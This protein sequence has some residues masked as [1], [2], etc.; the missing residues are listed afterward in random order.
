MCSIT[1]WTDGAC[2]GN[3]GPGGYAAILTY[4]EF[5]KTIAGF[6]PNTTNNRMELRAVLE[7]IKLLK[8]PCQISVYTDSRYVSSN[9]ENLESWAQKGWK[10]YRGK[11]L[12]NVDLWQQIRDTVLAGGHVIAFNHVAGH[13]GVELNEKCDALA[14]AQI[15]KNK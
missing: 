4:G 1:I 11:P 6:E 12:L 8:K 7:S 15:A 2:S 9:Y 10:N 14:R 13:A 3:P 5:S